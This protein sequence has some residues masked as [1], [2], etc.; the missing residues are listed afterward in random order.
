M[1]QLSSSARLVGRDR[2]IAAIR[3][4]VDQAAEHGGALV[5]SGDA[6]VGKTALIEA[7]V[8]YAVSAGLRLLRATGAQF[9]ANVTFSGLHQ[10]LFPLL[11]DH[12]DAL[13]E[14]P[15]TA[16]RSALGLHDGPVPDW[17]MLSHA[18]LE[19]LTRAAGSTPILIVVDDVP[20][21]DK[22]SGRV[23]AFIARRTAGTRLG[24]LAT[25]RTADEPPAGSL[26][27]GGSAPCRSAPVTRS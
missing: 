22:A 7:A 20:W 5:V 10:L 16:L 26:R 15:R 19:L 1:S 12:L 23:L 24:F 2:D 9:E 4:F 14:V 27:P 8:S 13:D 25:M 17:M 6:G 18:A 3:A 21:L 11:G